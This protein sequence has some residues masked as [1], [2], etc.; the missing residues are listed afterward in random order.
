VG[1]LATECHIPSSSFIHTQSANLVCLRIAPKA[2]RC[3][4]VG[5]AISRVPRGARVCLHFQT[6]SRHKWGTLRLHCW[7]FPASLCV[8]ALTVM[9]EPVGGT[10]FPPRLSLSPGMFP[11]FKRV[12]ATAGSR[13]S[14]RACSG[15]HDVCSVHLEWAKVCVAGAVCQSFNDTVCAHMSSG[16][17]AMCV[18]RYRLVFERGF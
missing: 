16:S 1:R 17:L 15:V 14:G 13:L 8:A 2:R 6:H 4:L 3:L 18:V 5:L 12:L 7:N 10:D 11:C 9:C